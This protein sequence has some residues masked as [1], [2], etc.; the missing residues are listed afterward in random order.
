MKLW[1]LV[2]CAAAIALFAVTAFGYVAE[3]LPTVEN[4]HLLDGVPG[5]GGPKR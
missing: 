1:M 2:I 4:D 3:H 5:L